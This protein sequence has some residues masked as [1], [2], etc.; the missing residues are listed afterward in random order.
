RQTLGNRVNDDARPNS[1]EFGYGTRRVPTS[2]TSFLF[3]TA[4]RCSTVGFGDEADRPVSSLCRGSC[5]SPSRVT[6][7]P[8]RSKPV[9]GVP[10]DRPTAGNVPCGDVRTGLGVND[11]K[12]AIHDNLLYIQ[13]KFPQVA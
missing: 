5:M 8:G 7:R 9:D 4:R 10:A 11:L 1:G 13:A 3:P 6:P 2:L 12:Q